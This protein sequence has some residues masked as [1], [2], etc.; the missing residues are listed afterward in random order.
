MHVLLVEDDSRLA[1]SLAEVLLAQR[2]I[3]DLARDGEAGWQQI[4]SAPY[5]L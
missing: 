5:D 2:Y 1:D 3:V 4:T